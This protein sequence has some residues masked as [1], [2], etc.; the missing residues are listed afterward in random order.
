MFSDIEFQQLLDIEKSEHLNINKKEWDKLYSSWSED[1]KGI[2]NNYLPNLLNSCHDIASFTVITKGI[3][4]DKDGLDCIIWDMFFQNHFAYRIKNI[5]TNEI[6]QFKEKNNLS[7]KI[8]NMDSSSQNTKIIGEIVKNFS[9]NLNILV[10][11]IK[12]LLDLTNLSNCP[13]SFSNY[14]K[15]EL[16]PLSQRSCILM[17]KAIFKDL[18]KSEPYSENTTELMANNS[19]FLASV[20]QY[21]VIEFKKLNSFL[22][23][24]Q[25]KN[26]VN[27][28]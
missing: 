24:K 27:Q 5:L 7:S 15:D 10:N 28:L 13:N 22:P 6:Q 14:L 16:T 8:L 25:W 23:E 26:F 2:L 20:L 12:T 1:C 18:L 4:D 9:D 3:I 21:L 19:M 17:L 11:N